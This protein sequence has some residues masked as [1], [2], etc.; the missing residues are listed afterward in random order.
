MTARARARAPLCR[1]RP[2]ARRRARSSA[3]L[4]SPAAVRAGRWRARDC[5]RA[6]RDRCPRQ[7]REQ[8]ARLAASG[9]SASASSILAVLGASP[10]A[11]ASNGATT[12]SGPVSG[13]MRGGAVAIGLFVW[14]ALALNEAELDVGRGRL[15]RGD[16]RR[17]RSGRRSSRGSSAS[18]PGSVCR[19]RGP[20]AAGAGTRRWAFAR[21]RRSGWRRPG[22]A[23]GSHRVRGAPIGAIH[24]FARR[25]QSGLEDEIRALMRDGALAATAKR[26][27]VYSGRAS[28]R[29]RRVRRWARAQPRSSASPEPAEPEQRRR[30]R[31]EAE[32]SE[33]AEDR[34]PAARLASARRA[35]RLAA[36]RDRDVE[37][38]QASQSRK[39]TTRHARQLIVET[40]SS[41]GVD[42]SVVRS[43]R[44]RRSRSSASSRAGRCT[45]DA[46][47]AR[48]R[49]ARAGRARRT[50]GRTS[51]WKSLAHPRAREPDHRAAERPRARAGGAEHAHRGAGAGQ[52]R[53]RH[54]GAERHRPRSSRCA[55]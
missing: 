50:A 34:R 10:A 17:A 46:A 7:H 54:R 16:A 14:G 25:G 22:S 1:Q 12:K 40:L 6:L 13:A 21:M 5:G 48:R 49:A 11:R 41:F 33:S 31:P 30:N 19:H 18:S 27:R 15:Q 45:S 23:A 8:H 26:R 2:I 35:Q 9:T 32:P 43:T 53:R 42:A 52:A 47:E 38:P 24:K 3:D 55:A 20:G 36:T 37:R 51:A 44:A 39:P 4:A 29:L 28:I